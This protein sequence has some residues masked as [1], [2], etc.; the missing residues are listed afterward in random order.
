MRTYG[1]LGV[2]DDPKSLAPDENDPDE[3]IWG[4]VSS[5]PS[6]DSF[7][8]V[9]N[10]SQL[11]CKLLLRSICRRSSTVLKSESSTTDSGCRYTK[12]ST[13]KAV[14]Q[15]QEKPLKRVA[16]LLAPAGPFISSKKLA[17]VLKTKGVSTQALQYMFRKMM[18]SLST[19]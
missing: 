16:S 7:Q 2:L 11:L 9:N 17:K 12:S 6:S 10:Y 14:V 1:P 15:I 5:P 8:L 13:P 18:P 3:H 4:L 19:L